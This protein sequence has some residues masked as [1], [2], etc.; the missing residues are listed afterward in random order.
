M[1]KQPEPNNRSSEEPLF[2]LR[3]RPGELLVKMLGLAFFSLFGL[4]GA[5]LALGRESGIWEEL[6]LLLFGFFS[7]V[8][9]Y[10]SFDLLDFV[11]IRLY[12]DRIVRI[13]CWRRQREIMLANAKYSARGGVTICNIED[14]MFWG[15]F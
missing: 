4:A 5:F 2:V 12:Q 1:D 10:L 13:S 7:I 3:Y 14:K 9:G 8:M 15:Q 11:E 6:Y